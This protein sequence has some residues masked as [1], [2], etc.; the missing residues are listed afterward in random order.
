[1]KLVAVIVAG[2]MA[3]ENVAVIVELT[4]TPLS[5]F[6]GLVELTTGISGAVVKVQVTSAA[7][8]P[9]VVPHAAV[10]IVAV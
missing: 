6:A 10:V 9:A 7:K 2:F 3:L 1:M 8:G 5:L 4:A